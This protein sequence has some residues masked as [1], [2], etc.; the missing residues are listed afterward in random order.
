MA[1]HRG[2]GRY[3]GLAAPHIALQQPVHGPRRIHIL[4]D[5][6]Q[7]TLLRARGLEGQHGFYLLAH[8]LGQLKR[9]AR[10][11]PRFAAL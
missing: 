10:H 5:L 4:S 9:N 7:H 3:D 2:F 6:A 11:R 1:I 8:T